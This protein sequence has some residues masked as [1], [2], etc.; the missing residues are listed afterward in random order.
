MT[1]PDI[2]PSFDLDHLRSLAAI[3]RRDGEAWRDRRLP[4]MADALDVALDEITELRAVMSSAPV[5][6]M[7]GHVRESLAHLA[8]RPLTLALSE[9]NAALTAQVERLRAR[10]RVEDVLMREGIAALEAL[11]AQPPGSYAPEVERA[12]AFAV[13]GL[14]VAANVRAVPMPQ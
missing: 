8:E 2:T 3:A 1:R 9:S 4:E 6:E 13:R 14:R 12:I 10:Q 11:H 7:L 5:K